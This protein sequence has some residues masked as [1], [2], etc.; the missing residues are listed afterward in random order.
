MGEE[1]DEK[2][3]G[4]PE[5]FEI[6]SPNSRYGRC[7]HENHAKNYNMSSGARKSHESKSVG[8]GIFVK[9]ECRERSDIVGCIQTIVVEVM[10]GGMNDGKECDG[11][12]QSLV[13]SNVRIKRKEAI[14]KT[15]SK[16]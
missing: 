6:R 4:V 7:I 3:M 13:S 11:P 5:S 1:D 15:S 10:S 9:S 8:A 14:Y 2:M 12:S 16:L